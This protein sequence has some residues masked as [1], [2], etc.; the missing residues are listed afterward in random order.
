MLS[1]V[2]DFCNEL[3]L[4][5]QGIAIELYYLIA[6][7]EHRYAPLF[8]DFFTEAFKFKYVIPTIGMKVT[9]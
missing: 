1:I 5:W 7:E 8:A 3:N 2:I 6:I 4:G 9:G